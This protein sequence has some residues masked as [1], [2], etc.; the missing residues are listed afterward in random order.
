ME[1][2]CPVRECARNY[3]RKAKRLRK[4][5]WAGIEDGTFPEMVR[6]GYLGWILNRFVLIFRWREPTLLA[7]G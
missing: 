6:A 7:V 1:R 5:G 4:S 3:W 2:I